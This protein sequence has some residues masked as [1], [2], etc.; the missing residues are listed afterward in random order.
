MQNDKY[1]RTTISSCGIALI[2]L[3]FF[4]GIRIKNKWRC[5]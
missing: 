1:S 2:H 5:P 3:L 4:I